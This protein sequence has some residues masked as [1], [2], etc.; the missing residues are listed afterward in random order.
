MILV[1]K[2]K[3]FTLVEM[4]IVLVVIGLLLAGFLMPLTA[5][6]EQ[7]KNNEARKDLQE[8]KEALLGFTIVNSRL[9]CPDTDGDGID[10]GCANTNAINTT[11]G[12]LPWASLGLSPTDPWNRP[13]QYRVNNVFSAPFLLSSAGVGAGGIIRVCTDNTCAAFEANNVPA[14]FY[15]TGTNGAIQPPIGADEL[16]NTILA[17]A[18]FNQDFVNHGFTPP[19]AANGEFDDVID[20][21]SPNVLFGRM[22]TAGRLP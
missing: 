15:S 21:L 9:P 18:T 6:L 13:Y 12:N 19:A 11:G 10:D 7:L 5:Q 17:G 1:I 4:A 14:V 16:E 8:I 3:G 2:I 20:W 22:V